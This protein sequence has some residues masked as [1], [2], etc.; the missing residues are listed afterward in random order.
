MLHYI[1]LDYKKYYVYLRKTT[2]F[3]NLIDRPYS[4]FLIYIHT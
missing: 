1:L 4:V 3:Q 2:L